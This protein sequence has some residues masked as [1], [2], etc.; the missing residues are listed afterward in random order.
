MTPNS[1]Q[2]LRIRDLQAQLGLAVAELRYRNAQ[3]LI[4]H[5]DLGGSDGAREAGPVWFE[6]YAG[7]WGAGWQ[8]PP[9]ELGWRAAGL[10]WDG[11]TY[12]PRMWVAR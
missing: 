2:E 12:D 7:R 6:R 9:I 11:S 10:L 1:D 3:A 8:L 5:L 4:G